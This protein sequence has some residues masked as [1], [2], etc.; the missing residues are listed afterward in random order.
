MLGRY[1]SFLPAEAIAP[2]FGTVT[3]LPNLELSA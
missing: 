2:I 3:P 1:G